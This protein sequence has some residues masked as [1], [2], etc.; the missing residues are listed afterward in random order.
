MLLS[1]CL[2]FLDKKR[3]KNFRAET[4]LKA[5]SLQSYR[6]IMPSYKFPSLFLLWVAFYLFVVAL[7]LRASLHQRFTLRQNGCR[8]SCSG[9]NWSAS[10]RLKPDDG[11]TGRCYFQQRP[12]LEHKTCHLFEQPISSWQCQPVT[13]K[14]G[15]EQPVGT[16]A[17]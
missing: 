7:S 9:V 8:E 6:F 12:V 13:K 1:I 17:L 15:I 2:I 5:I 4:L 14:R 16:L 11:V 3:E 10:A